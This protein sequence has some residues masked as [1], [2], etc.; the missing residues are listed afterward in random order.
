MKDLWL[1]ELTVGNQ[2]A[3]LLVGVQERYYRASQNGRS[4][5]SMTVSDATGSMPAVV[6]GATRESLSVNAGDVVRLFGTVDEF[7]E[8]PQLRVTDVF[9]ADEYD[10]ADLMPS[11]KYNVGELWHGLL[12]YV[13]NLQ[14]DH[15][16][17]WLEKVLSD[18]EIGSR[19]RRWP[20][21]MKIHHAYLGGLLEHV[22]SM[23][24]TAWMLCNQ[25]TR[26]NRGLLIAGCIF[27]DLAKTEELSVGTTFGYTKVGTLHGHILRG[28][29]LI[30]RLCQ[31]YALD[32]D[33]KIQLIHM[34][35]SHH[36]QPEHGA[37]KRPC[38]PEAIALAY[39]DQLDAKLNQAFTAIDKAQGEEFTPYVRSLER[40]LYCGPVKVQEPVEVVGA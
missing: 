21:G 13:T 22:A 33:L 35:A 11:T 32:E 14:D 40:V 30:E 2:F 16:R 29:M 1:D 39:I 5:L 20:A 9:I 10:L 19:L 27:H 28:C 26:L 24:K 6:W 8:K 37:A 23:C 3:G 34:V 18:E 4:R 7:D 36:D 38:T 17:V 25:H 31:R 12:T 15:M